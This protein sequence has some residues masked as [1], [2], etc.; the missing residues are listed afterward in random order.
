MDASYALMTE[1]SLRITPLQ[2]MLSLTEK[3]LP[4]DAKVEKVPSRRDVKQQNESAMAQ[5]QG[6]LAGVP[7][8]PTRKPRR[9]K[10]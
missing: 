4:E 3:L 7:N 5:L 6:M 1:E 9:M 2:D 10:K 8:A